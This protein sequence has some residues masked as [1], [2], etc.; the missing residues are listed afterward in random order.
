[1][2]ESESVPRRG[3]AARRVW[4]ESL[5][6][7]PCPLCEGT[8]HTIVSGHMQH[9]LD[10]QTVICDACGLVFTN[11]IPPEDVYNRFYVDAYAEF[12]GGITMALNPAKRTQEPLKATSR[13]DRVEPH[14]SF[15]GSRLLEV[16]PGFGWFMYWARERGSEVL[17][18]EPSSEFTRTLQ[19]E[20]LPCIQGT[21]EQIEQSEVGTFDMIV[22]LHVLEH[23]YDPNRA[24]QKCRDLI[25]D[26]GTLVIEVPSIVQ[27]YG[28][29]DRY[30]LRYV[31][32][33]SFSPSTL[34]AL[35][36]KHGF[37]ALSVEVFRANFCAPQQLFVVARKQDE[38]PRNW[39]MPQQ[40]AAEVLNVLRK[41]RR[42]WSAGGS[43]KWHFWRWMNQHPQIMNG[44]RQGKQRLKSVGKSG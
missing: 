19:D 2:T 34:A 17:G 20:G 7:R 37:E 16:G 14:H 43:A 10:L 5:Q 40:S 31:H 39:P 26:G 3:D 44:L 29:L 4:L 42:Q 15:K 6:E 33:T 27:P 23:F 32:P 35:L 9:K 12:Y 18:I 24:L 22:M 30:A 1:M 13:L 21:F 11:P 36:A 8:P 38:V 25:N 41:Y 28:S